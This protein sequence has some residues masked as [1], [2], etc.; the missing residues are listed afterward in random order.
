MDYIAECQKELSRKLGRGIRIVNGKRKGRIE[1]EYY[2]EDDLQRL[3]DALQHLPG[4]EK[5]P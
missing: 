2:G 4:K 5:H 1:L 3:Y